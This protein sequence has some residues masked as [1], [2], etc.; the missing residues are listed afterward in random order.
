[1]IRLEDCLARFTAAEIL[2]EVAPCGI[3]D[4][5]VKRTK[6][7]SIDELPNVL[8]IQLKRFGVINSRKMLCN[9]DFPVDQ[10]LDLGPFLSTYVDESSPCACLYELSAVVDHEG[11]LENGHYTSYVKIGGLWFHCD[12]HRVDRVEVETVKTSLGYVLLYSRRD[13]TR[14]ARS[15]G[16][17]EPGRFRHPARPF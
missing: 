2:S 17:L 11:T 16:P 5:A 13:I 14:L 8:V 12:N 1:M 4:A 7:L 9:I 15:N 3:C 6:Q 10:F